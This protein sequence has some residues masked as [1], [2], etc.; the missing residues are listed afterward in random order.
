MIKVQSNLATRE[1]IPAFLQG[2][3]P[4]SLADLSWTDPA[5]GVQDCA[6]WPEVDESPALGQ[7]QRYGAETL[8]PDAQ[9]RV[10]RVVRAI[11][12]WTQEEITASTPQ[13]VTMR[14]ARLALLGVG[15]LDD[16]AAAIAGLPSPQKEAAQIEWEYSTEV[17]RNSALVTQLAPALGLNAAALDALF[18]QAATL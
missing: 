17:K 2:L 3:A 15:K 13:V 7:Y 8:T 12:P 14:Q 4:E 6:W 1:P 18:T 9:A 5:L 16:V 11:V 10:V